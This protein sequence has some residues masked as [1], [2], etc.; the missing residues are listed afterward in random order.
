MRNRVIPASA[1]AFLALA[2]TALPVAP[3][4][5]EGDL[6]G[7]VAYAKGQGGGNGGG[8]GGGKGGHGHGKGGHGHGHSK[9]RGHGHELAR[10][11]GHALEHGQVHGLGHDRELG[12]G[13]GHGHGDG[14][15]GDADAVSGIAVLPYP[16][17]REGGLTT[18]SRDR[19]SARQ[20][21]ENVGGSDQAIA[22]I[23]AA[24]ADADDKTDDQDRVAAAVA[25]RPGDTRKRP[26]GVQNGSDE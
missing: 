15:A 23:A 4:L 22:E 18:S 19:P 8:N 20:V 5:A 11:F 25:A 21:G 1:A 6:A 3:D 14:P 7:A 12:R 9:A 17:A 13:H 26:S 24:L 10:G 2:L 16:T